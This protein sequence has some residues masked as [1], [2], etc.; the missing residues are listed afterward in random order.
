MNAVG[1]V[2][3]VSKITAPLLL[4]VPPTPVPEAGPKFAQ[5]LAFASLPQMHL[6]AR[7]HGVP[8]SGL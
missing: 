3:V 5:R 2:T 4:V 7:Q 8:K 6:V 1:T